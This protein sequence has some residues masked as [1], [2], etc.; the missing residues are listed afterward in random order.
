LWIQMLTKT[1]A[2]R[3][4]LMDAIRPKETAEEI[5]GHLMMIRADPSNVA[6]HNDTA[7]MYAETGRPDEAAVHFE[8]VVKLQP[9]SPAAY[10][11][12]GTAL[13]A[14]GRLTEAADRFRK[15]VELRPDWVPALSRLAWVLAIVPSPT[16]RDLTDAIH[17]GERAAQLTSR[18]DPGVLDILAAALAADGQFDV[19]IAT[20]DGALALGPPAPLAVAVREHQ[21]LYRQKRRYVYKSETR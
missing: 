7:L 6:L 16:P 8:A 1:D 4:I 11:N 21:A 3:S 9:D 18:R 5:V 15:A 20:C 10:F 14:A 17:L 13:S 12:I 19:A 2:D